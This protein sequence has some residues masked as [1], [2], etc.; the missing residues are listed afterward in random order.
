MI[1]KIRP[2]LYGQ[3]P[4]IIQSD[5]PVFVKFLKSYFEYLE[6][7][8]LRVDVVIDNLLLELETESFVLDSDDNKVV[9]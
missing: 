3:L 1:N 6:A 5:H 8:E 2:L 9:L 4:D 7:G